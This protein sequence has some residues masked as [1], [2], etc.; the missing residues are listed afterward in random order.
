[1]PQDPLPNPGAAPRALSHREVLTA[2][3]GLMLAML[4]GA[5]DSTIVSTALPTIVNELGG[6]EHLA[7]VV[8]A[9]LL[10]QT[11]VTPIYGKLGDLYGRKI[12][13]QS[14]ILLFLAGSVLCG[15]S[16]NMTQLIA[17][18]AIQGLGGG[19]L[20]VVSQAVIADIV[21]MRDRGRYQGFFGALFGVSSIAGPLLGGYFTTHLSWRWIF[22]VN[23]PLGAVALVVLAAVLPASPER[24]SHSIDYIGAALLT[25]ALSGIVLA[26]DIAGP[27]HPWGSPLM[28]GVLA[29]TAL[30]L[31]LFIMSQSKAAEPILPLRL[32]QQRTFV[33]ASGI[34]L[35]V[36]FA[37]F[38]SVTYLPVYL[39]TVQ[40]QSPT[41]SGMQMLPMM[42][43]ML[44]AS[45]ITGQII[46]RTGRYRVFPILGTAV[47]STGLLMLSRL[48]VSSSTTQASL[49]MLLLGLG[50][51][52]VMQTLILA[53]QNAADYRDL[54]VA[55]SGAT[56]FRSI[57]GSLGTA[58]L[59]T[60]FSAQLGANLAR[61]LP[62][63]SDI[64]MAGRS[65]SAQALTAMSAEAQLVYTSSF[66]SSLDTMFL[67]ATVVCICGFLLSWW[68]P[69][70]PLRESVAVSARDVGGEAAEAFARPTDTNNAEEQL[71]QAFRS[72]ADRDVQ[73]E[74]IRHIVARSGES[75]SPLAAWCLFRLGTQ[76]GAAS[77]LV[78]PSG[79]PAARLD[80]AVEELR[81]AG[82]ID[83]A[84]A[85][86]AGRGE[87]YVL[88]AAGKGTVERLS[89]ARRAHLRELA[90]EWEGHAGESADDRLRHAVTALADHARSA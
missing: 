18:R 70:R 80:A 68:L 90:A 6:L 49:Y 52:M 75:L 87:A 30:A 16:Q 22:Y 78:A 38:G 62:P 33:V 82:L 44:T 19:G 7:W 1:L 83:A 58:V 10:A 54:G 25:V 84:D 5:L 39:Q 60:V 21:P 28:L 74:H 50:L 47:M 14:A 64:A 31:G 4:L 23:L 12:I 48:S 89:A 57:G 86:A 37:M 45:I 55:T 71:V 9:Y 15:L 66:M 88:T 56:L 85:S 79:V 67:V 29:A 27:A 46:S 61:A 63:G 2:F 24:R 36:G 65:L 42:V 77:V 59:G 34:G 40:A 53:V 32:F 26:V 81:S 43:G 41:R 13:L 76:P 35:V 69:E 3:S 17:F 51:G 73:R 20:M 8:T 72:L 11:V